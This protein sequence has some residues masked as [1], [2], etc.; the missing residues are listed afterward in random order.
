MSAT[1]KLVRAIGSEVAVH[2]VGRR[3]RATIPLRRDNAT[4]AADAND[5]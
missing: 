1:Q 4:A 3:P 2:K 5:A